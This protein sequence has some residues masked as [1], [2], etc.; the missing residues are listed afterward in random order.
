M[1]DYFYLSLPGVCDPRGDV[2][3]RLLNMLRQPDEGKDLFVDFN[4][5]ESERPIRNQFNVIPSCVAFSVGNVRGSSV[6]IQA[7]NGAPLLTIDNNI[8]QLS[9]PGGGSVS[10]D[11]SE[12]DINT[13]VQR[14]Q[15][16]M[17]STDAVFYLDCEEIKTKPFTVSSSGI[18][19]VS[20]LGERNASTL[21]YKNFFDVS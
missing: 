11:V 12:I 3:L 21:E 15:I 17:N 20:I 6:L 10:F 8:I 16:C 2:S 9:I 7:D 4:T 19:F 5:K 18:N 1:S 13:R 14:L